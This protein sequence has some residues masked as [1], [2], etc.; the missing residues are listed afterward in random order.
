M[1]LT[2]EHRGGDTPLRSLSGF[3]NGR[4]EKRSSGSGFE[5]PPLLF[6]VDRKLS[7]LR[8]SLAGDMFSGD[9]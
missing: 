2:S 1:K 6:P 7:R 5:D 4:A 9:V 3:T 8:K